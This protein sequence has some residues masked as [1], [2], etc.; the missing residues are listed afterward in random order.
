LNKCRE[1]VV[2]FSVVISIGNQMLISLIYIWVI[3]C[4]TQPEE[5]LNVLD[6]YLLAKPLIFF[7]ELGSNLQCLPEIL[8]QFTAG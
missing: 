1:I 7:V 5:I 4:L 8:S 2:E 6:A 3:P